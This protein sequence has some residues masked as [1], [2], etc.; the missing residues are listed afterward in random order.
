MNAGSGAPQP[1][2]QV[3]N[4][5][6]NDDSCTPVGSWVRNC[7]Q[8]CEINPL[9]CAKDLLKHVESK[10]FIKRRQLYPFSIEQKPNI[11]TPMHG[12][13][14]PAWNNPQ[15]N[16]AINRA[17]KNP[18]APIRMPNWSISAKLNNSPGTLSNPD[19]TNLNW[20]TVMYKIPGYCPAND[21]IFPVGE[22]Q[23]LQ[24]GR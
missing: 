6:A 22:R 14:V 19:P 20:A 21:R 3:I 5:D 12:L 10:G 17:I 11:Q 13:F 16:D 1:T 18:L 7:A 23:D 15:L 24:P 8:A 4:I 2:G 9:G